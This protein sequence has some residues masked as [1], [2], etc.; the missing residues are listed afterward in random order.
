MQEILIMGDVTKDFKRLGIELRKTYRG[1]DYSVCE[2]NEEE[3]KKLYDE[4]DGIYGAWEN[5]GWRYAEGSN[6]CNPDTKVLINSKELIGWYD[7]SY[8]FVCEEERQEYLESNDGVIEPAEYKDLL[9]YLCDEM[10][11]SQHRNVCALT[12]HLAKVNDMKLSDLF[13]KYQG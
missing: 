7:D 8:D 10:G 2:V 5:G 9:T 12:T 11:C 6:Q 13:K 1:A 3:F 4:P